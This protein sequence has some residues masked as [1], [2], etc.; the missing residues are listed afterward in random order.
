MARDVSLKYSITFLILAVSALLTTSNADH[1]AARAARV[2]ASLAFGLVAMAYALATPKL[3]LKRPDGRR[4][5][6]AWA[7]YWPYFVLNG[8]GLALFRGFERQP[9]FEEVAPNLFLGRR[10]TARE[11][12]R[13]AT[14]RW[15]AVLDLAA[16][17]S[18]PA[19][20]RR[21]RAYWSLPIL[22]ATGPTLPE[23]SAAVAW[24]V[25]RV[26]EGPVYVHCALGHGRSATVVVAYLLATGRA[27]TVREGLA[28]VQSRRPG[29]SLGKPQLEALNRYLQSI[30]H[31]RP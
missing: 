9:P 15:S 17:F 24:L 26:A 20:L 23:L 25:E 19:P 29:V 14:P 30:G 22:D 7:L 6:W 11:C 18:E 10:L 1:V 2:C 21:V 27:A 4:R 8:L 13:G 16:E 31:E 28:F 5:P 3:L 12:R